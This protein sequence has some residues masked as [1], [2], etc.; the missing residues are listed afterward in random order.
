[1]NFE[2]SNLYIQMYIDTRHA[3]SL[4]GLGLEILKD[5]IYIFRCTYIDTLHARSLGGLGLEI[6]KDQIYILR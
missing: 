5:Q 6:L 2:G 4:G 1:M 3:R